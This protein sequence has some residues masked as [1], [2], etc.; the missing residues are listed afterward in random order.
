MTNDWVNNDLNCLS[1]IYNMYKVSS[2]SKIYVY[3]VFL[4]FMYTMYAVQLWF[5]FV[6]L[7]AS[8]YVSSYSFVEMLLAKNEKGLAAQAMHESGNLHYHATNIR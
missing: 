2:F 8:L 6:W 5:V 7:A 1:Q 4:K 3:H